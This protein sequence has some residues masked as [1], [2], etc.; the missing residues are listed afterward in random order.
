MDGQAESFRRRSFS[1]AHRRLA[2]RGRRRPSQ[3]IRRKPPCPGALRPLPISQSTPT[4]KRSPAFW[5]A[6]TSTPRSIRS[7]KT[8]CQHS[9]ESTP[10]QIDTHQRA[11]SKQIQMP[12]DA[13]P[14][15]LFTPESGGLQTLL[16]VFGGLTG[17]L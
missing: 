10:E 17:R 12:R 3:P 6:S 1:R 15:D 16:P 4:R 2:V 9:A 8:R 14:G 7:W 13:K 11:L 5:I